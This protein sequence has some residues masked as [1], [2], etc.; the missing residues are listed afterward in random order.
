MLLGVFKQSGY[1]LRSKLSLVEAM[2]YNLEALLLFFGLSL[3]NA[4]LFNVKI[5]PVTF[6]LFVF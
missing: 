2:S 1:A 3:A 6:A 4:S 5:L